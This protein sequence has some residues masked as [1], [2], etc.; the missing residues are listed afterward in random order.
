MMP[1]MLLVAVCLPHAGRFAE[2]YSDPSTA[3][4]ANESLASHSERRLTHKPYHAS[5]ACQE[6]GVNKE[7]GSGWLRADCKDIW[8]LWADSVRKASQR[9]NEDRQF[10]LGISDKLRGQGTPCYVDPPNTED[11]AGSRSMRQ[12]AAIAYA[13]EIGCD[14]LL[15]RWYRDASGDRGTQY[16]HRS[17]DDPNDIRCS[18]VDWMEYF[19]MSNHTVNFPDDGKRTK[20]I[21]VSKR[22]SCPT[23]VWMAGA[24]VTVANSI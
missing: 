2:G 14:C 18:Q 8:T 13:E 16:C 24:M 19:G 23:I 12:F 9:H 11:G 15:P 5:T 20:I 3:S 4:S 22:I 17:K 7:N 10:F 21:M 1:R 6:F